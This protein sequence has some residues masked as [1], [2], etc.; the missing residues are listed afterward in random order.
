M[1]AGSAP[2]VRREDVPVGGTAVLEGDDGGSCYRALQGDVRSQSRTG[3]ARGR[4]VGGSRSFHDAGGRESDAYES[5]SDACVRAFSSHRG[6]SGAVGGLARDDAYDRGHGAGRSSANDGHLSVP[7]VDR[8]AH[9]ISQ[10]FKDE[11]AKFTGKSDQLSDDYVPQYDLV[12]HEYRVDAGNE[13]AFLHNIPAG[14][15]LCF[16]L[17]HV[18]RSATSYP[19]ACLRVRSRF[20]FPVDQERAKN[21]VQRLRM[22][23]FVAKG[24]SEEAAL[25]ETFKVVERMSKKMTKGFAS[26]Q[27]RANFLRSAVIGPQ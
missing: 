20:L 16:F 8:Q 10:R 17:D 24:M 26:D 4:G 11:S 18:V 19:D 12:P 1:L 13:F 6:A 5:C 25:E 21:D 2:D 15:A 23:D 27:H 7:P 22:S 14:D 9:N 3:E